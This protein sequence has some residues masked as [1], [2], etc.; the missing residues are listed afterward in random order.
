MTVPC[1]GRALATKTSRDKRKQVHWG[2][3]GCAGVAR[4]VT[5]PGIERSRNGTVLAVASRSFDKAQEFSGQFN[6]E[7]TYGCYEELLGD[8]DVEAVYIPLPNSMHKEWTLKAAAKGKHVLCEKPLACNAVD[9][10]EMVEACRNRGV[11][12][13]EAFAHRFHPHNILVRNLIEEGRIGRVLGMTSNHSSGR[14]AASDIRLS[15]E[16][17][18]GILMDKGCYCVNT[19][20]FV[21]GSEPISAF[22]NVVYGD[23]SGVDER[24]IALLE[25]PDEAKVQFDSSFLLASGVYYQ[26]YE[27]FGESGRILVPIG[28]AQLP[29]YRRGEIIDTDIFITDQANQTEKISVKGEH[30]W[31]LEVEYFADCV[32]QTEDIAFPSENGLANMKVIDAIY[33]SGKEARAVAL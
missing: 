3:L 10:Q 16:L 9:S 17:G 32:L 28:F 8:P 22:A 24:V 13:M 7:R 2:I 23:Q 15:K 6:A 25:F 1:E 21:L 5:I 20:R 33:A 30:Q 4:A 26:G 31:K 19:A 18:G 27:V 14:P 11:L 12:L 29:T